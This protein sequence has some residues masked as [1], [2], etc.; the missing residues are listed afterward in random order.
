MKQLYN[1]DVPAHFWAKSFTRDDLRAIAKKHGITQGRDKTDTA[2]N[3][4]YGAPKDYNAEIIR[5]PVEL[6]VR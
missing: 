1:V 4:R 2:I 6:V 5:F 3:L